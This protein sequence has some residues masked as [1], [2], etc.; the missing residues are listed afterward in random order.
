MDLVAGR[1][2]A[3]SNISKILYYGAMQNL[4]FSSLQNALFAVAFDD[5]EDEEFLDKKTTRIA[6]STI[7]TLLR[8]SGITGA[9]IATVKNT[10]M[11]FIEEREKGK[12]DIAGRVLV[13]SLQ[14]SPPIGSKARKLYGSITTDM[15]N[16][17]VYKEIPL[18]NI[19][20]P[21][22]DAV[23][24]TVEATTNAP[25]GR[26]QRKLSN[27]KAASDSQNAA[28]QRLALALGWDKWSLGV[29]RP[30]E[31][32]EA[33]KSVKEKKK[34]ETLT[35]FIDEQNKEK[36]EGKKDITCAAANKNGERCGLP[37]VDGTYCTIH[38]RVEK[39]ED[40]K[41]VQCKKIKSDGSRCKMQTN[42]KS[43]LCYYHD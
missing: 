13:E 25:L 22:W 3:K 7:D 26:V 5:D 23:G 11:K 29:D 19:D 37:T 35:T 21:I 8:G 38:A 10:I 24:N 14:I 15:W 39:R 4:I 20:N 40:N 30:E 31:I 9:V 43:G 27:L 16:K 28:W 2:D 42:A 32:E 1:G 41:K 17:D 33:K 6:N 12:K 18:Y 34:E 36:Q